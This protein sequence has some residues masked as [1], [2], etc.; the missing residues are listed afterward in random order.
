MLLLLLVVATAEQQ[1]ADACLQ[2]F[3]DLPNRVLHDFPCTQASVP[4]LVAHLAPEPVWI[5]CAQ[6]MEV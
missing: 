6:G 2:S 4:Q 5:C 3:R 1:G